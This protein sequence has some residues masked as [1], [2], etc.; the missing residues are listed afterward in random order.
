MSYTL[1]FS[2]FRLESINKSISSHNYLAM[3]YN[4]FGFSIQEFHKKFYK[5]IKEN[6]KATE[7]AESLI[8]ESCRAFSAE[9]F[10]RPI[11]C[12]ATQ[13]ALQALHEPIQ[14]LCD[15]FQHP[16]C[17]PASILPHRYDFLIPLCDLDEQIPEVS[18]LIRLFY[19]ICLDS[20]RRTIKQQQII[21][22]QLENIFQ[23]GKKIKLQL[24][25]VEFLARRRKSSDTLV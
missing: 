23:T 13:T 11:E 4:E 20:S 21:K 15:L 22:S 14:S 17:L 24:Q 2:K 8:L 7:V 25:G 10:V 9:R 19:P 5:E 3:K 1:L 16:F 12:K 18:G 6:A